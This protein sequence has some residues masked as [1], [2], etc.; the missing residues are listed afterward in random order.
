MLFLETRGFF[1]GSS[2]KQQWDNSGN[3]LFQQQ[4]DSVTDTDQG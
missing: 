1:P 2:S 3:I 4:L